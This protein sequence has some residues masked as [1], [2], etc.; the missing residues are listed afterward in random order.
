[1]PVTQFFLPTISDKIAD[2]MSSNEVTSE[3]KNSSP[4][5]QPAFFISS[6]PVKAGVFFQ[7]T[8]QIAAQHCMWEWGGKASLYPFEHGKTSERPLRAKFLN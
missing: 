8:A 2:T 7:E 6:P 1:M 5:P 4:P 3:K